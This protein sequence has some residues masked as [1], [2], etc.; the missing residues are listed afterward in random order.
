MGFDLVSQ[1]PPNY[2]YVNCSNYQKLFH[3]FNFRKNILNEKLESF[4]ESL[5]EWENMK[6]NG[7]D[8][9]WDC[10]NLKFEMLL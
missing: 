4:D 7:Y 2:W 6:N 9:I 8:R 1:S 3:R 5:T 10:G